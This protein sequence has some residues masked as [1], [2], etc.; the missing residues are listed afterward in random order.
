MSSE[1]PRVL[2]DV[3][4]VLADFLTEFLEFGNTLTGV[5]YKKED[6]KKWDIFSYFDEENCKKCIKHLSD[7]G[8]AARLKVYP[9]AKPAL[10]AIKE[11]ADLFIVTVPVYTSL[12]WVYERTGWLKE[13]FG[14]ESKHIVYTASKE[15]V[16]GDIFI[17]DRP[18]H[19]S[20]WKEH[21]PNG[22]AVLWSQ[23]YNKQHDNTCDYRINDWN[24]LI[25][26][27]KN[28]RSKNNT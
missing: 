7:P 9:G 27:V 8:F 17:D 1:R 13:H 28:A 11:L 6:I 21:N 20:A 26:I 24:K 4:G 18:E 22:I 10:K 3:D 19:T 25:Q 14:I 2:C 15:L 5:R 23:E 16:S 12:T